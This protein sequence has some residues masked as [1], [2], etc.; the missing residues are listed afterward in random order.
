M[1]RFEC[2]GGSRDGQCILLD[3]RVRLDD[4][5]PLTEGDD[6]PAEHYRLGV[7]GRLHFSHRARVAREERFAAVAPEVLPLVQQLTNT[8]RQLDRVLDAAD[9]GL[10]PF[11]LAGHWRLERRG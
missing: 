5:I 2:V 1:P 3:Q 9:T 8:L 11:T 6:Q 7:D 4:A 10:P